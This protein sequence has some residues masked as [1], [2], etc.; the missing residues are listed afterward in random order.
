MPSVFG[1]AVVSGAAAGITAAACGMG[2][3]VRMMSLA[4]TGPAA[5]CSASEAATSA[6]GVPHAPALGPGCFGGVAGMRSHGIVG[7]AG[8]TRSAG[9]ALEGGGCPPR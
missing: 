8:V 6:G 9:T 2:T 3:S 1:A 7:G 4:D 5:C